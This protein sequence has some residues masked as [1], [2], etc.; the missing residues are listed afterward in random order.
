[1]QELEFDVSL[2]MKIYCHNQAELTLPLNSV[3]QG[4]EGS[5]VTHFQPPTLGQTPIDTF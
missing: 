3:V 2:P 5:Q 4:A 1:M